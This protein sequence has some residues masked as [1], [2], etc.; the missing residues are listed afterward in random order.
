M[1]IAHTA[2]THTDTYAIRIHTKK[3]GLTPNDGLGVV[4]SRYLSKGV[5]KN[6]AIDRIMLFCV[7][8]CVVNFSSMYWCINYQLFYL[9]V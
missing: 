3:N 4:F 2:H 5:T 9:K 8:L 7:I 6:C 1:H